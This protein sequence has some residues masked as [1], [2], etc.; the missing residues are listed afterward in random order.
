MADF[1]YIKFYTDAYLADTTHLRTEEHG[2]NRG[3][4]ST[5]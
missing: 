1:P 2:A 5:S 4:I 3:T